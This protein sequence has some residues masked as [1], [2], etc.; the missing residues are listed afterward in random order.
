MSVV[1]DLDPFASFSASSFGLQPPPLTRNNS[2][3]ARFGHASA[4][5][6]S[7]RAPAPRPPTAPPVSFDDDDFGDFVSTLSSDPPPRRASYIRQMSLSSISQLHHPTVSPSAPIP[8]VAVLLTLFPPLFILPSSALL[9]KL[10]PLPFPLRQRVLAHPSTRRFLLGICEFGR[11]C[12]RI[13]AGRLRRRKRV[14]GKAN[15][16]DTAREEREVKEIVRIWGENVGRL[17]A[18]L[19]GPVPD[20]GEQA[21]AVA[22]GGKGGLGCRLCGLEER[23]VV[24]GLKEVRHGERWWDWGWG[25]HGS[26]KAFWEKHGVDVVK[27]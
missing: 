5:S 24:E 12:G 15:P 2:D 25:G 17:K 14:I 16:H 26:C 13:I 6:F 19:N 22:Q 4:S 7:S 20:L 8:P 21:L 11:V 27:G 10:T 3:G 9:N 18:A 23:E 1:P